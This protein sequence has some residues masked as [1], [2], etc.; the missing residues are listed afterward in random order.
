MTYT[1]QHCYFHHITS[2]TSFCQALR[3]IPG[4]KLRPPARTHRAAGGQQLDVEIQ[5]AFLRFT[6]TIL[7]GYSSFLL[8]IVSSRAGA[9][10]DT[11]SL[12]DIEGGF[13]ADHP[14]PLA[15]RQKR[16]ED[17]SAC[18]FKTC[19]DSHSVGQVPPAYM[20]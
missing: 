14:P 9:N 17:R 11:A 16:S 2:T 7:K 1:P 10:C 13:P 5:E 3:K 12:F 8:P 15:S 6:A 20:L 4:V 18:G 19:P